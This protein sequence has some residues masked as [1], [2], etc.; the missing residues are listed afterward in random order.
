MVNFYEHS[1]SHNEGHI[2]N[3]FIKIAP[4]TLSGLSSSHLLIEILSRM[5][6]Y[7]LLKEKL[8][9]ELRCF[10]FFIWPVSEARTKSNNKHI[11]HPETF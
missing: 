3:P 11:I 1:D 10:F 9:V 5:R 7:C 8:H 6:I 2:Y 4:L